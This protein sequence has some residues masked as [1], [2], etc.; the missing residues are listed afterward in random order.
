MAHAALRYTL[1][2]F[3]SPNLLGLHPKLRGS[4]PGCMT[5]VERTGGAGEGIFQL[6]ANAGYTA[7]VVEMLL[8]SHSTR[9]PLH[10]LPAL[11]PAWRNGTALGLRGR[12][13][14]RVDVGWVNGRLTR[15]AI[16]RSHEGHDSTAA[17]ETPASTGL[18]GVAPTVSVCCASRVCGTD[19]GA[20]AAATR[21]EVRAVPLEGGGADAA[22]GDVVW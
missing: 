18:V 6:D 15:A 21:A 12:G 7:A 19:H 3:A 22:G 14:W 4:R 2:E 9:C 5:C 20:L 16:T 17:T 10:L 11:P 13:A 8:Q 1:H